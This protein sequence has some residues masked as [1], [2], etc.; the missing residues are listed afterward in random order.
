MESIMLLT[1]SQKKYI[2][3]KAIEI[4]SMCIIS[5]VFHLFYRPLKSSFFADGRKM[6][7]YE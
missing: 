1:T 4:E 2:K 5:S 3:R 7:R 6:Y